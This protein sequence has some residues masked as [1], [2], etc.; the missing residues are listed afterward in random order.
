MC[1]VDQTTA[2]SPPSCG[3][4]QTCPHCSCWRLCTALWSGLHNGPWS[5][6][7]VEIKE[8]TIMYHLSQHRP[9]VIVTFPCRCCLS[10]G[11]KR[12]RTKR[13]TWTRRSIHHLHLA[14]TH[15]ILNY[16]N[17]KSNVPD[18][19]KWS[20][21]PIVSPIWLA[22]GS[23][24]P[25]LNQ[26]EHVTCGV[27]LLLP[28]LHRTFINRLSLSILFRVPSFKQRLYCTCSY[29]CF[30]VRIEAHHSRVTSAMAKKNWSANF[31]R[32]DQGSLHVIP[33]S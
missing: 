11:S 7:R 12:R 21:S 30:H 4:K 31:E 1:L 17:R 14:F 25:S 26:H 27:R 32:Q 13:I 15:L 19:K 5:W 33:K 24:S 29:V 20:A 8:T 10:I 28:S 9:R 2:D 18:P 22:S 6:R 23:T 16:R 3:K